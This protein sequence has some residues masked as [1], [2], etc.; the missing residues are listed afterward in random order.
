MIVAGFGFRKA[1]T[2]D[3]LVDVFAQVGGTAGMLTTL[4][5]KAVEPVFIAFAK[6]VNLP[7]QTTC[8]DAAKSQ[9]TITKSAASQ[10]AKGVSSVAEATALAAAGPGAVLTHIRVTSSDG[11][12]TCAIAEG[13]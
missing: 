13:I 5:E 8:L 7:I 12:A 11:C 2:V 10:S 9:A 6:S 3:S 4:P 1:A